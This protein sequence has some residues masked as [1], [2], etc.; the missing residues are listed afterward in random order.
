MMLSLCERNRITYLQDSW[1]P[2]DLDVLYDNNIP[3]YKCLQRS[4]DLI[5]VNAGSIYWVQAV[6][7][8]NT[9]SWNVGP[10][11]ARQY[12]LALERYEWNKLKRYQSIVPIVQLSWNLAHRVKVS[13]LQLFILIKNC[14]LQTLIKCFLLEKFVKDKNIKIY[15][16]EYSNYYCECCKVRFSL[17]VFTVTLIC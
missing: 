3:V 16:V 1:W 10:L 11:T 6:G 8:C 15:K 17:Y 7:W 5:W 2:P 12:Q 14:L 13:D 9:I 4:G